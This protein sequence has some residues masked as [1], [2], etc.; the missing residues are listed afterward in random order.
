M[1]RRKPARASKPA[2][3]KRAAAGKKRVA[4]ARPRRAAKTPKPGRARTGHPAPGAR[5]AAVVKKRAAAKRTAPKRKVVA[6]KP[7][8]RTPP[9]P[10][11]TK[12]VARKVGPAGPQRKVVK[13]PVAAAAKPSATRSAAP[14]VPPAQVNRRPA[15]KST[16][17]QR[18]RRAWAE[19][20]VPG[21]PS[22][23]DLDR[24]ASSVRSGRREMLE[25]RGQHTEASPTLTGGDVDADWESAYSVGDEAPGGDNPTPDQDL[26]DD[27]GEAVGLVYED[28]EELEGEAKITGRDK[29]RWELDP[30]SS[31]D[32]KER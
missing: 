22:S 11:V 2:A 21:P 18:E 6:Q 5:K 10:L 27:I 7:V 16:A 28:N 20:I 9:R 24:S 19:G 1:A 15:R 30:A 25:R 3:R 31:D 8:K 13:A 17:V 4:A 14:S 26:V 32:F 12:K 29:H 23:L